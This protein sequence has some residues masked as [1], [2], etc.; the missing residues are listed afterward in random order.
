MSYSIILYK[1]VLVSADKAANNA[2]TVN[3]FVHIYMY[4]HVHIRTCTYMYMYNQ[5]PGPLALM[6]SWY[7]VMHMHCTCVYT[8]IPS[9][10]VP[11]HG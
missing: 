2:C 10:V 7:N 5:E 8:Y 4:T 11:C 1:Y 9:Q 6:G 3:F